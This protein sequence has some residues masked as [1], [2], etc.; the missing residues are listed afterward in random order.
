MKEVDS[1]CGGCC[2]GF[3]WVRGTADWGCWSGALIDGFDHID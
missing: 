1:S 3:C 2:C